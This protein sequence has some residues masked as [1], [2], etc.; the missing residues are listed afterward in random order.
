MAST[1]QRRYPVRTV[2]LVLSVFSCLPLRASR[3]IARFL[4]FLAWRFKVRAARTTIQNIEH[5]YG[6]LTPVE[7][8]QLARRSLWHTACTVFELPAVWTSSYARLA[9][10]IKDINGESLLR[11]GIENGPVLLILPHFG[12]WELLTTY[13]K[14]IDKYSCMYSPRRLYELEDLINRCRSRFGGE[15]LPLTRLGFRTLLT[16][17]K[18]GG[19]VI[20]LPDQVPEEG[21]FVN[22]TFLGRAIRTGTFPH[23][24]IKRG[25]LKVFTM[26]AVRCK[27]GFKVHIQDV[28]ED[29]YSA[30]ASVSI[31]ALDHAIERVVELDPA[32]YQWEYKRFRGSAE[33][34]R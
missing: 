21:Q 14:S 15:F 29:I 32:Q 22:S 19:I 6:E 25:E 34:Y 11:E 8:Q 9:R 3:A 18:A 1:K 13:M 27:S 31:Q 26:V 28:D 24:L 7:Q 30:D 4:A 20:L 12:N 2:R 33:I 23:A 17:I 10:W 16:R 5:C